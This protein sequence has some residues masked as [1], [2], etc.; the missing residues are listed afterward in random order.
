MSDKGK[1]GVHREKKRIFVDGI[2]Y[3]DFFSYPAAQRFLLK[4]FLLV[5]GL[6]TAGLYVFTMINSVW[7]YGWRDG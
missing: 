2:F 1:E 7:T 4:G 5:S 6:A 3:F